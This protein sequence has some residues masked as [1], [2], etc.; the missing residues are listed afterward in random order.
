MAETLPAPQ[1]VPVNGEVATPVEGGGSQIGSA[2]PDHEY[3]G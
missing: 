3:F 2:P 1:N